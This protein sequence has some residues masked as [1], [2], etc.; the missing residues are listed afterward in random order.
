MNLRRFRIGWHLLVKEL[1]CSGIVVAGLAL[2]FAVCFLLL[3]F[4]RYCFGYD[5]AVPDRARV[6]VPQH[7]GKLMP[8]PTWIEFMPLP[9]EAA[10]RRSALR[11]RP[12]R[13]SRAG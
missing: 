11:C 2:G 12:A 5:S 13:R 3:D 7:R 6:F 8:T 10:A 4:V 1:A 9:F